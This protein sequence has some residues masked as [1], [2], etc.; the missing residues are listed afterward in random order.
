MW[1]QSPPSPPYNLIHYYSFRMIIEFHAEAWGTMPNAVI[2]TSVLFYED[3]FYEKFFGPWIPWVLVSMFALQLLTLATAI[4]SIFFDRRVLTL[5]AV[6]TC[7]VI[8]G[9]MS[10]V[11]LNLPQSYTFFYSYELGFWLA[12]SSLVMFQSAFIL[13]LV[14][15]KR[16]TIHPK[17]SSS[18]SVDTI[19]TL[20][21]H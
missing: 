2:V 4:A 15:K 19:H 21:I 20:H 12:I 16:Q 6:I 18:N 7:L 3:G 17:D 1:I 10:Y 5:G 13:S 9:L 11:S 8:I 14:V